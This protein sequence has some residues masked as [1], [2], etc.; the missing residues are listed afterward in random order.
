MRKM[1]GFLWILGIALPSCKSTKQAIN[2]P[3]QQPKVDTVIVHTEHDKVDVIDLNSYV[4]DFSTI[5]GKGSIELDHEGDDYNFDFTLRMIKDSVIWI[6]LKKFGLEGARVLADQNHMKIIDRLHRTYTQKS[7]D[8]I[9][10]QIGAPITFQTLQS[11]LVG[12]PILVQESLAPVGNDQGTFI[13]KKN[14]DNIE[15]TLAVDPEKFLCKYFTINQL[16][17]N[18]LLTVK[19]SEPKV[20]FTP[21][22]FSYLRDI[23]LKVDNK[24][25]L[26]V[27]INFDEVI[28]NTILNVP[29]EVPSS[30]QVM[31]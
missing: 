3:I 31:D 12:D 18:Q 29:F 17:K 28:R 20:L 27:V 21:N 2:T 6:Q 5:E 23:E 7:W 26:Y 11:I 4:L 22:Y 9:G 13:L 10:K 19:N 25:Q 1:F 30:Y 24:K 16:L 8:E 14:Q 15:Y